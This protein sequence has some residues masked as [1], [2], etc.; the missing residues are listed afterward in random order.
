[1]YVDFFR[2]DDLNVLRHTSPRSGRKG[3]GLSSTRRSLEAECL[4]TRSVLR[5]GR[6][7]VELANAGLSVTGP[8]SIPS[9]LNLR[10]A[11]LRRATSCSLKL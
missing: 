8:I 4:G 5:A 9:I 1:V 11:R 10:D 6:H 2:S 3:S 7:A